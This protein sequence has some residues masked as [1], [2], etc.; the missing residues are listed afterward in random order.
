MLR[1]N[2][3]KTITVVAAIALTLVGLHVTIL[4][5]GFVRSALDAAN[6]KLTRDQGYWCLLGS[7]ILLILGSLLRGL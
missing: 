4:H 2:A 3:P 5:I 6:V 1:T 7:P